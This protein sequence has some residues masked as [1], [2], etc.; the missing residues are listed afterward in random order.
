[1]GGGKVSGGFRVV[2]VKV[3]KCLIEGFKGWRVGTSAS[4]TRKEALHLILN[5]GVL[6]FKQLGGALQ[7]G[8]I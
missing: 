3:Q 2:P 4:V 8:G 6:D 1:V 5:A 7:I